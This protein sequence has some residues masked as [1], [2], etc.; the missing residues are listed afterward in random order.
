L[1]ELELTK[2]QRTVARRMATRASELNPGN[3]DAERLLSELN[4][5]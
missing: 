1:A 4:A 5:R 3:R 2:G